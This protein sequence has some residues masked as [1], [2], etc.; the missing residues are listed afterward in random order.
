MFY[1][2]Y[3]T[4]LYLFLL[5]VP[6]S[7]SVILKLPSSLL[8]VPRLYPPPPH[9]PRA[10]ICVHVYVLLAAHWQFGYLQSI[11]LINLSLLFYHL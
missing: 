2:Y 9:G 3:I 7:L 6:S 8:F 4:K 11:N 1:K 10:S 5:W